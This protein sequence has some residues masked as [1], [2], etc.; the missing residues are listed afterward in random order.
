MITIVSATNR[1][2]A[3]SFK[4]A[5]YYQELLK[6]L[7][8]ESQILDLEKLPVDFA[9]SALYDNA[10]KNEAFNF[11]RDAV[12]ATDKFIFIIPE[13]NGSFPGVLKTF[14]DGQDFPSA[15]K[16]KKVALVGLSSGNQ[17]GALAMSHFTDILNY[18][19]AHVFA[20]KPRITS[21][22][23]VFVDGELSDLKV[24]NLVAEQVRNFMAF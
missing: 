10:G 13:Y 20:M 7:G 5:L 3:Y 23:K 15:L 11:F 9:F 6:N 2:E 22:E 8:E 18:L 17:G 19:N 4:I 14:I 16:F 1:K 24:R 21:V 12:N